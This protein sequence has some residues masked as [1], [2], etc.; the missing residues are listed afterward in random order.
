MRPRGDIRVKVEKW[1]IKA[2]INRIEIPSKKT[3]KWLKKEKPK[4]KY[5]YYSACCSIPSK[6]E[7]YAVSNPSDIKGY[8][9]I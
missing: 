6:F 2:G 4:I 9:N 3:L 7:K 5:N 1:A 8:L